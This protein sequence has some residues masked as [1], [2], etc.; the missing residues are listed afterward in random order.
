MRLSGVAVRA[1]Q[2][3]LVAGLSDGGD[4]AAKLRPAIRNRNDLVSLT[5]SDRAR[6]VDVLP[7]PPPCGLAEL[8]QR[9]C[10]AVEAGTRPRDPGR[11]KPQSAAGA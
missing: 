4:L 5:T 7:D 9:S 6:I 8:P 10:P 2:V 3:E 11:T 1:D